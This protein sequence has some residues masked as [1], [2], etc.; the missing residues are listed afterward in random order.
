MAYILQKSPKSAKKW[1][2]T[3]PSGKNIDFGATGYSDYT[4]H[5]DPARMERYIS[6]HMSRENW[7]KS[8]IN[9]AGFWSRWLLWNLPDFQSSMHDIERRFNITIEYKY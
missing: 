9:T 8:G 1:R 2:I 6:R 7:E 4:L 5:K 3:T